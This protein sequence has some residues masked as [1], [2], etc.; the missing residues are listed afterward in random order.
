MSTTTADTMG[1]PADAGEQMRRR[2][3]AFLAMCFGCFQ[4]ASL[5]RSVASLN[6]IQAGLEASADEISWVPPSY[7]IA[8]VVAHQLSGFPLPRAWN[9]HHVRGLAAGSPC[10][11]ECAAAP[12]R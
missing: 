4:V 9:A 11:P 12:R 7:L 8:E 5:L 3:L 10:E 2:L 6:E 1:I